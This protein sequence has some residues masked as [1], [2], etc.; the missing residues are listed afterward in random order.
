M[1]AKDEQIHDLN[2]IILEQ[3][4]Q[5]NALAA[6]RDR[7]LEVVKL[8]YQHNTVRFWMRYDINEKFPELVKSLNEVKEELTNKTP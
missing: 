6:E 5:I 3:K 8:I 2:Q 4:D 7:L 1:T